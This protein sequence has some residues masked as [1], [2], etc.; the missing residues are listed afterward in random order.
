MVRIFALI[1]F[2]A[3]FWACSESHSGSAGATSETTNGIALTVVDASRKPVP[4]ARL[5]LYAKGS[6]AVLESAET[7]TAGIAE[8]ALRTDTI[9]NE[10]FVE[11][12]AG[13]DS[14]L[15]AWMPLDTAHTEI[16]LKASASLTV[17][18]GAA[19]DDLVE[20]F[21]ALALDS[22]PYMALRSGGEYT[23]A[24]V[25]SGVFN[26]AA[27]DSIIATVELDAGAVADTLFHVPGVTREFVF[28]NFDD[29]DNL[30]N[31]AKD[32]PNSGWYYIPV[33]NAKF[34]VPDTSTGFVGALE[35]DKNAGGK[36]LSL[37]FDISDTGFVMIGT[38]LGLDTGY[39]DLSR[40]TAV[41]MRVRGDCNF[42]VTL[43]HYKEVEKNVYS[44]ILWKGNAGENWHEVVFRPGEETIRDDSYQVHF[45]DIATEI[46]FFSVYIK[47]G[48][49]LQ[50]DDIVF[51]GIDSI[52]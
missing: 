51:E 35:D 31:V 24:H 46:G 4:Y 39:Y 32:L 37:K 21:D 12:I 13:E 6:L 18:T 8:F 36:F 47:S 25:P 7:D 2:A 1:F 34:I 11:G 40:I 23:F 50:I 48:S 9:V 26:I 42:Y 28:E 19:K 14:S 33:G 49:Y 44:R 27:G 10:V 15:M 17:R 20:L 38:R 43:E 45:G 29:G 3:F 30:N 41:R 16:S 22:T 5:T 52:Q